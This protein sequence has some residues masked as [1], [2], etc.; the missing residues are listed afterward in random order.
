MNSEPLADSSGGIGWA[1]RGAAIAATRIASSTREVAM[2]L[3]CDMDL[4][5]LEV[6]LMGS[7]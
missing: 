7:I 1:W 4:L 2:F 5:L 3:S 6:D